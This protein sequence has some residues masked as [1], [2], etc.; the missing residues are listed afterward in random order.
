MH[1]V[2]TGPD[3]PVQAGWD[4]WVRLSAR[5]VRERAGW[6]ALG[7]GLLLLAL[8]Y[9][10]PRTLFLD[11]GSG[12]DNGEVV[13]FYAPETQGDA[14]F[15]WS[16]GSSTLILPGLGR[17]TAPLTIDLQLSSGRAPDSA[18]LPV[19]LAANGHPLPPLAL[20][21]QTASYP[22][23]IDPAWI[24]AG[25]AV[26][27][28][29]TAPTFAPPGEKRALGFNADFARIHFPGGPVLPALPTLAELLLTAAL[30][31]LLVRS[32]TLPPRWAGGVAGGFLAAC[33][34]IVAV[35]RLWLTVFSGR[36][37]VALALSLALVWLAEP[38]FRWAARASGHTVPEWAWTALRGLV[39]VSAAVK[40][41]GVLYPDA[42]LIDAYF[43]LKYV[44]Y[45][46]EV[47][48]G[49]RAWDQYFGTNLAFAVMPKEEWGAARAFIPYSPFF[50]L[51][52]APL[53]WL[54]V[55]IE[56]TIPVLSALADA[57]K[58]GLIFLLGLACGAGLRGLGAPE[59]A[60][61]GPAAPPESGARLGVA[62]AAV[63]AVTPA[64]FLLLQW[65]NWP[66]QMA[67]WLVTCWAAVTC[68]FWARLARPG[69][70]LIS[71]ALLTLTF[72]SYTVAVAYTGLLLVLVL[73]GGWILA[74][75]QRRQW[76]ALALSLVAASALSLLLYY[77]QYAGL[78]IAS[79]LPTFGNALAEQGKL[80]TLHPS[81]SGFLFGDLAAA[82]ASYNLFLIF[83]LGLAG[84]VALLLAW[85]RAGPVAPWARVWL[86]AWLLTFPL[87]TLADFWID[88]AFKE[89]WYVLPPLAVVVGAWL[90]AVLRRGPNAWAGRAF[91]GVVGAVL[92]WQSLSLWVFRLLFHNR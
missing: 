40:I 79:T 63:Y 48:Q 41:A 58:V 76:A 53:A 16:S 56:L 86:G 9:Q 68:L 74:P 20:Q 22:I 54:P 67:L 49:G 65:A 77:G 15:R 57:L 14:D 21:P 19:A 39:A 82:M 88:Q 84:A 85:R 43:H 75:G 51:V 69:V 38:I 89:F 59:A 78:V 62:A 28:D 4:G 3:V 44:T 71:T 64:G 72:L 37:L 32:V 8:A 55:G 90:L 1:G 46:K 31:Y 81:L 45:M 36:L 73:V 13:G 23:Q 83:G 10:S 70:W 11:L 80:T 50:Y 52:S 7:V 60:G 34:A 33:A 30:I 47:L 26:R 87:I 61:A 66:T 24:G 35:D 27:L 6:V 42:A 91:V 18:P 25:G 5:V 92:A 17:P 29:F 2:G 12:Y